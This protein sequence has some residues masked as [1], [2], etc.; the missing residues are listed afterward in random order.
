[1]LALELGIGEVN[2]CKDAAWLCT[3]SYVRMPLTKPIQ[4]GC[5]HTS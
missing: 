5:N 3:V 4:G 2:D 1:M